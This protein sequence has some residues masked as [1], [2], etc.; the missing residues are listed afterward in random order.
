MPTACGSSLSDFSPDSRAHAHALT[1]RAPPQVTID[2]ADG[3]SIGVASSDHT[4]GSALGDNRTTWVLHTSSL[5]PSVRAGDVIGVSLDQSDFP[6][7]LKFFRNGVQCADLRGPSAEPTAIVQLS[8]ANDRV[9][10]NFGGLPWAHPPP[11]GFEG[12]IRSRS[13]L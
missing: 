3:P 9:R 6:V 10:V 11:H 5:K 2:R 1:T 13:I 8:G 7:A 4:L 12:I